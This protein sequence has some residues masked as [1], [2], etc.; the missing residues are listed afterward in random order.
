MT[1]FTWE[2]IWFWTFGGWTI[3]NH[4]FNFSTCD[5]SVQI[6]IIL[7]SILEVS[8]FLRFCPFLPGCP[9]YWHIVACS[10]LLWSLYFC[11]VHCNFSFFIYGCIDLSSSPI[12]MS[13]K[14]NQFCSSSQ[15]ASLASLI[16]FYCFLHIYFIYICSGLYDF[17]L[18]YRIFQVFLSLVALCVTLGCS[19]GGFLVFW[20]KIVSL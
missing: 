18:N 6:F 12:F 7:L 17:L 2:P 1:E 16:F 8:I 10:S 19:F 3:F 5:L 4:S 14:F 15:W 11:D 9:F 13:L 20:S